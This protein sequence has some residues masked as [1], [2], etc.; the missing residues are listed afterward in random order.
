MMRKRLKSVSIENIQRK[1][2][3]PF[4]EADGLHRWATQFDYTHE[5]MA[6]KIGRARSS[7]TETFSLLNIPET[8]RQKLRGERD[9]VEVAVVANGPAAH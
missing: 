1:D 7:V 4:E 5:D 3:T 9:C 2:L 8:L 6:R